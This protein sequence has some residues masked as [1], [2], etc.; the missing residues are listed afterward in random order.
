MTSFASLKNNAGSLDRLTKEIEKQFAPQG[1]SNEDTRFWKPTRDKAGNGFAVIRFL[2]APPADGDDG[3][4][5]AGPIWDHGFQG[6]SG[7][8]YIEKSRT[9]LGKNVK[10]PVSEFNSKLWKASNDDNSPERKQARNQKRRLYYI[11]NVLVLKDPANPDNE[12]KVFLYKYGKKVFEKLM[13]A[14][15][16]PFDEQGRPKGHEKY[17]PTNAYNPFD[18]WKGANLKLIIRMADG[19]PNYN[20][21]AFEPR[22]PVADDDAAIEAIWKQEYGIKEFLD[23]SEFK[24]YDELKARFDDVMELTSDA[25]I[26]TVTTSKTS[27]TKPSVPSSLSTLDDDDDEDLKQFKA[28]AG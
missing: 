21:S 22:G 26:D 28:L 17:S 15:E 16:P 25:P 1:K 5:W 20:S 6:P 27:Y 12:G 11:S 23:P 14:I 19:Y 13:E 4:P 3:M 18:L 8:W 2:P 24:S 10:D 9:S 7:K